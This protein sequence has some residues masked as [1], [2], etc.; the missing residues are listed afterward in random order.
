[1]K[2]TYYGHACIGVQVGGKSLLFDPFS[3]IKIDHQAALAVLKGAGKQLY[4]LEPGESR[5]F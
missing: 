4:L 3:P 1:M 5:D 2:V